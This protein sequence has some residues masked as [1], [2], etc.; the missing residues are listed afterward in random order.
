MELTNNSSKKFRDP[1]PLCNFGIKFAWIY[2]IM[3]IN[4]SDENNII[5]VS[6]IEID[7]SKFTAD[8]NLDDLPL[9]ATRNLVLFPGVT[10][11]VNL[12]RPASLKTA[13][14]S[15]RLGMPVG[16]VCQVSPDDDA[17]AVP[18]GLYKYGVIVDV[19]KVDPEPAARFLTLHCRHRSNLSRIPILVRATRNF[20][21]F[22]RQSRIR[23]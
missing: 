13:E 2:S 23:P 6:H 4:D 14:A 12:V 11:P 20:S 10:F 16:L 9:I 19:L 1:Q 18:S 5:P 7:P 21:L 3:N 17:P 15:Y 8:P 22:R